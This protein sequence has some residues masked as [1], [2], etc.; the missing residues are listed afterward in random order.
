MSATSATLDRV[1]PTPT[2]GSYRQR[3]RTVPRELLFHAPTVIVVSIAFAVLTA[4]FSTGASLLTIFVGIFVLTATLWVAR[5]FGELE[6]K[7]LELAGMSRIERP[8]WKSSKDTFWS[9]VLTPLAD[10]HGWMYLVHG[11]FVNFVVGLFTWGVVLTWVAG[12]A[13]GLTHWFWSQFLPTED[14]FYLSEVI[15]SFFTAGA[16]TVDGSTAEPIMNF[17]FGVI[18]LVTLPCRCGPVEI[19]VEPTSPSR[20]T[21]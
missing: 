7:R 1:E 16:V 4:L 5:W 20:S 2:V 19:P 8:R 10:G 17:I 18:F 12:A 13:G 9:K 6:M 11:V 14:N 21:T 15:V 3:W